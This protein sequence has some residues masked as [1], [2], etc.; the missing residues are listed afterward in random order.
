MIV[1]VYPTKLFGACSI[2]VALCKFLTRVIGIG[3]DHLPR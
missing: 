2:L 3:D 1:S